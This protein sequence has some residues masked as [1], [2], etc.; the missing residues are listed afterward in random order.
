MVE[1]KC[2]NCGHIMTRD[3]PYEKIYY[4]NHW[5]ESGDKIVKKPIKIRNYTCKWCGDKDQV[6]IRP[7]EEED[8]NKT[9]IQTVLTFTTTIN[10]ANYNMRFLV[11]HGFSVKVKD[12]QIRGVYEIEA[13]KI[14][15]KGE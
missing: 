13:T 4:E 15:K 12:T 2:D 10:D 7:G 8:C 11:E 14:V 6:I 9:Q 3:E 5:N 1:R